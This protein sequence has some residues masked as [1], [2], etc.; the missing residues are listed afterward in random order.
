MATNLE[1]PVR[2]DLTIP[3]ELGRQFDSRTPFQAKNDLVSILDST[4]SAARRTCTRTEGMVE[5]AYMNRHHVDVFHPWP[6]NC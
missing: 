6:G 1:L 4:I 5:N 3:G 2:T